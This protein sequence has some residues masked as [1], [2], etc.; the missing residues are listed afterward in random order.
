MVAVAGPLVN[1]TLALAFGLLIRFGLPAGLFSQ[2]FAGVLSTIVFINL[3]LATFNLVPIPPLDGSK[4]LF[5]IIPGNM[6]EVRAWLERYSF[7]IL[8]FF[9]IFLWQYIL[10][11]VNHEFTWIT[12]FSL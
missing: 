9:I 7:F 4:I 6:P 10:P 2:S 12:G 8:I 11:V 1:I 3:V 5:S